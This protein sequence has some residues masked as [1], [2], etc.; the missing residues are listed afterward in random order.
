MPWNDD[1]EAEHAHPATKL[2]ARI[3]EMSADRAEAQRVARENQVLIK[4]FQPHWPRGAV[5]R[6]YVKQDPARGDAHGLMAVEQ[7]PLLNVR[8]IDT[9]FVLLAGAKGEYLFE[10]DTN[11]ESAECVPWDDEMEREFELHGE[12]I[13]PTY[14]MP[15]PFEE[16][17]PAV[18]PQPELVTPFGLVTQTDQRLYSPG[19]PPERYKPVAV[20]SL[21]NE[22]PNEN[23][24]QQASNRAREWLKRDAEMSREREAEAA[25]VEAHAEAQ[26][27]QEADK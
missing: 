18:E 4:S 21:N 9:G 16:P 19:P 11:G 24:Y 3:K 15:E 14:D 27:R 8:R 10:V 13:P 5:G 26:A 23:F 2:M 25:A 6:F 20:E 17:E 1:L 12:D 7:L 22:D